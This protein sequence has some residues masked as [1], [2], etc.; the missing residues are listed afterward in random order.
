M[1]LQKVLWLSLNDLGHLAFA[2]V[3]K[4]IAIF[5]TAWDLWDGVYTNLD[6]YFL[7]VSMLK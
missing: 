1:R 2:I 6:S 7:I 5:L 4:L 3:F